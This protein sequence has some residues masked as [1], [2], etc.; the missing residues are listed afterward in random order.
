MI[1]NKMARNSV[2]IGWSQEQYDSREEAK[3][4]GQDYLEA[5]ESKY[6][7]GRSFRV[8]SVKFSPKFEYE[9]YLGDKPRE[10]Y[11]N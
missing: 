3:Q 6:Q 1:A 9:I 11:Q 10:Y 8:V 7:A 2:R 4:A 5:L